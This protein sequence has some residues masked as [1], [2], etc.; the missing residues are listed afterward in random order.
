[1]VRLVA[2][3]LACAASAAQTRVALVFVGHARSFV[4]PAVHESIKNHLVG[5]LGGGDVYW[6][7]SAPPDWSPATAAILEAMFAPVAVA[8]HADGGED[9]AWHAPCAAPPAP[10]VA[11]MG[12]PRTFKFYADPARAVVVARAIYAKWRAAFALVVAREAAGGFSYDFVVRCRFDAGWYATAPPIDRFPVDR[13]SVPIQT[14]NGVNDQFAVAPRRLAGAY[15]GAAG[16]FDACDPATG[17]PVWYRTV[18]EESAVA[19]SCEASGRCTPA[20]GHGE[21]ELWQPETFL[22]RW[23][24]DAG[25]PVSRSSARARRRGSGETVG[26]PRPRAAFPVSRAGARRD[27]APRRRVPLRRAH[28]VRPPRY[29]ARRRRRREAPPRR[30]PRREPSLGNLPLPRRSSRA[31]GAAARVGGGRPAWQ[32]PRI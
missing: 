14:W 6:Y 26:S 27:H 24:K 32:R 4:R 15:F 25:A 12:V 2:L 1:M 8:I 20:A 11:A 13:V 22:W 9:A 21:P 30:P 17:F 19:V 23:L 3:L 29:G 7:F 16:A 5:G 10:D 31:S 18:D 28:A